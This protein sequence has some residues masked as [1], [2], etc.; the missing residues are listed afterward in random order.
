MG[1]SQSLTTFDM[2]G[3]HSLL[4]A[5]ATV[6]AVLRRRFAAGTLVDD[7]VRRATEPLMFDPWHGVVCRVG[8]P[9]G[10]GRMT[11]AWAGFAARLEIPTKIVTGDRDRNGEGQSWVAQSRRILARFLR[12]M[13]TDG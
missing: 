11:L 4:A 8:Q 9:F 10:A 7:P 12:S 1:S 6:G 2:R 5:W 13:W 3:F